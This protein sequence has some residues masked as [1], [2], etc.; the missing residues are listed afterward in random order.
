M[1][2]KHLVGI[3]LSIFVQKKSA[4]SVQDVKGDTAGV[5]LMGMMGN[6]VRTRKEMIL[7]TERHDTSIFDGGLISLNE[8]GTRMS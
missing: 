5:G 1:L 4:A 3:M 8:W 2:E 6:K 7:D